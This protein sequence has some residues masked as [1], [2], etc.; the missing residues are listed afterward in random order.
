MIKTIALVSMLTAF[1]FGT[2]ERHSIPSDYQWKNV[3]PSAGFPQSY[4]YPVFVWGDK[5][6]A[7][8]Q[9]TWISRDAKDWTKIGLPESGLNSAYQKYVQF[10]CAIYSLG[11]LNGNY[12]NFTI[13][14]QILRTRDLETWETLAETSN[15]PQ[16]IFYGL[17]VFQGKIWMVRG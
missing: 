3:T 2:V 10:K 13:D 9:G 5:M 15:L 16:R 4:N 6:V 7:F 14:T 1:C 12:Q 11:R 8:N 17:T